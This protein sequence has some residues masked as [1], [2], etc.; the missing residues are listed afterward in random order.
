MAEHKSNGNDVLGAQI[1][2]T[3]ERVCCAA[4]L[5]PLRW[6]WPDGFATFSLAMLQPA[7]ASDGLQ[8]AV[9]ALVRRPGGKLPVEMVNQVFEKRPM[10][11]YLTRDELRDALV[12]SG[13]TRKQRCDVCGHIERGAPCRVKMA[14]GSAAEF[15]E[16]T[17]CVNCWLDAGEL[18]HREWD[19]RG[20]G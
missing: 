10:C 3:P 11:F 17:L 7:L 15:A 13:V 14:P 20:R 16:Q 5:E 12:E 4:H 19:A 1:M 18:A 6:K 2:V 9:R 8:R